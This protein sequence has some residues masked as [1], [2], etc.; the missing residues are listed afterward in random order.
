[1]RIAHEL[2]FEIATVDEAR[3]ILGLK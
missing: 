2:D 3:A 1:V